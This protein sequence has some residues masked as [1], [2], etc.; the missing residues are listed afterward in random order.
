[1]PTAPT[2]CGCPIAA[3]ARATAT[4]R[5]WGCS[6]TAAC[7]RPSCGGCAP[8]ILRRPRTNA[9]YF[10]LYV[11]GKGG[12]ERGVSVPDVVKRA[13]DA[14]VNVHPLSNA[15][16]LRDEHPLVV[17]L[18]RHGHEPPAPVSAEAVY[19]LVRRHCVTAGVPGR[20]SHPTRRGPT[21][22]RTCSRPALRSTR[23][24]RASGTSTCGPQPA[25]P[26]ARAQRRRARRRARPRSPAHRPRLVRSLQRAG[27]RYLET[28]GASNRACGS[29]AHGSPTSFTGWHTRVSV[30]PFRLGGRCRPGSP[31]RS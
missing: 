6:A 23:C 3:L 30:S 2:C 31:T 15:T 21:G 27:T 24:Q 4:A 10:R 17:W 20:L 5:C 12:R 9:R 22:P 26:R 8:R 11:Y 13:I 16:G 29:P 28:A 25:M 14:W 1:M 7:A 18:G 19:R